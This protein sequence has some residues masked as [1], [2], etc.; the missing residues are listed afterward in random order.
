MNLMEKLAWLPLGR[1][2]QMETYVLGVWSEWTHLLALQEV[3]G[4]YESTSIYSIFNLI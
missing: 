4:C 3:E 1:R 2:I